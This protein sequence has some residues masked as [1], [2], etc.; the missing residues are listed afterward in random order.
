MPGEAESDEGVVLRRRRLEAERQIAWLD[1]YCQAQAAH[2]A[3]RRVRIG[4]ED[5][6]AEEFME[7]LR[8]M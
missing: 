3:E 6:T 4:E 5:M 2:E 1:R 8:R 7:A